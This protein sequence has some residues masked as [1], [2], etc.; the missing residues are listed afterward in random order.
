MNSDA[1][2]IPANVVAG[3]ILMTV[4]RRDSIFSEETRGATVRS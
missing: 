4:A 2:R 3:T 1:A